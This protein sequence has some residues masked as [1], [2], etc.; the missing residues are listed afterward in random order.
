MLIGYLVVPFDVVAP[1]L[2]PVVGGDKPH[3]KEEGGRRKE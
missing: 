1:R 2:E 3:L